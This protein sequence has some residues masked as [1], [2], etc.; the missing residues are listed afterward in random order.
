MAPLTPSGG[1]LGL[2]FVFGDGSLDAITDTLKKKKKQIAHCL[3]PIVFSNPLQTEVEGKRSATTELMQMIVFANCSV[4]VLEEAIKHLGLKNLCFQGPEKSDL[5]LDSSFVPDQGLG[6]FSICDL[7]KTVDACRI[8]DG[9]PTSALKLLAA[10]NLGIDYEALVVGK[11]AH[12]QKKSS[13]IAGIAKHVAALVSSETLTNYFKA[14]DR[15]PA[16]FIEVNLSDDLGE[17]ETQDPAAPQGQQG[18]GSGDASQSSSFVFP[19][20]KFA[21]SRPVPSP[22]TVARRP[23][24]KVQGVGAGSKRAHEGEETSQPAAK[25]P[26]SEA[27]IDPTSTP[28]EDKTA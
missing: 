11:L 28:Q 2:I 16:G 17:M 7:I 4:E 22:Q 26:R 18:T 21:K 12:K 27:G 3:V 15:E 6:Y 1:T 25:K 9:S 10:I 23:M 19:T 5:P 24:A 14:P 20:P 13:V 8:V